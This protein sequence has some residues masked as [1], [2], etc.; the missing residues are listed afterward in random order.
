MIAVSYSIGVFD[1]GA[2]SDRHHS[3]ALSDGA[4][5]RWSTSAAYVFNGCR[6][7]HEGRVAATVL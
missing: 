6:R 3:I 2:G 7:G 1:R 4:K 5:A